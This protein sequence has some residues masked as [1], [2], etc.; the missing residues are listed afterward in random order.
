MVGIVLDVL[1]AWF[2]YLPLRCRLIRRNEAGLA[3]RVTSR[4]EKEICL[5]TRP[6]D[7]DAEACIRLF[8]GQIVRARRSHGVAIQAVLPFC[9]IFNRVKQG[10]VIAA[11]GNRASLLDVI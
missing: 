1:L 6:E 5:A 3:G 4:N 9:R 7:F 10:L 8:V 2:D 11:P